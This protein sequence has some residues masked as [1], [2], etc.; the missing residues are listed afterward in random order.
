MLNLEVQ[1]FREELRVRA[2]LLIN[3]NEDSLLILMAKLIEGSDHVFRQS[4]ILL[5]LLVL[6]SCLKSFG[7][8]QVLV[9]VE[10]VSLL[11]LALAN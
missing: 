2:Q 1:H 6:I 10:G 5:W 3:G 11:L 8:K 7:G 9:L 4:K